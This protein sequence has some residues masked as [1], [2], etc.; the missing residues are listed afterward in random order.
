MWFENNGEKSLKDL[1]ELG[2]SL[3][4]L[5]AILK[6]CGPAAPQIFQDEHKL[7]FQ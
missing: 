5:S 3:L 6:K 1:K 2:L 7:F 4:D